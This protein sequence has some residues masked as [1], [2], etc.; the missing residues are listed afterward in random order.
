MEITS[1]KNCRFW[2]PHTN[3]QKNRPRGQCLL[4][5]YPGEAQFLNIDTKLNPEAGGNI[6]TD[7]D[8]MCNQ[9]E[10]KPDLKLTSEFR[11]PA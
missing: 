8:F 6:H 4:F 5:S 2:K 9:H 3:P 7:A 11:F 10:K 1:C